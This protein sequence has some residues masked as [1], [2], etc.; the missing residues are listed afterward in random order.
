[1][2][3]TLHAL[4][5]D[6]EHSLRALQD[7]I[8]YRFKDLSLLQVALIH[9]SFSF[10][11]LDGG[12]HNETLEFLG[13]AVLDLAVG[14]LLFKRF[15]TMREGKL[16]RIRAALVNEQG[17]AAMAR[18]IGLGE[19]LLLGKGEEVSGGREKASILSC[20]YEAMVGAI[21]LDGGYDTAQDFVIRFFTPL[22]EKRQQDLALVDAKSGLQ[23]MLQER[24][25]E[26]PTY[27]LDREEGP[28]HARTFFVSV[29]FRDR[30]LGRGEAGSKKL[31]EQ[32]AAA[33]A[34]KKLGAGEQAT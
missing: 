6:N 11:R 4:I 21:F 2:G 16:T 17:L 14:L 12:K 1:M 29:W 30:Q 3:T 9:S 24:Y 13:D 25:N 33:A 8:G 31:A 22:V 27:V 7:R 10:E 15:P 28:A 34:L 26:G 23:E 5:Q 32:Q 20:A 18:R 19:H